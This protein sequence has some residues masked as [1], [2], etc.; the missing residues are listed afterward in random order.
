MCREGLGASPRVGRPLSFFQNPSRH[1]ILISLN[2]N[3]MLK[4]GNT[5]IRP[6]FSVDYIV[7]LDDAEILRTKDYQVALACC[8]AFRRNHPGRDA[9]RIRTN[10]DIRR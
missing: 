3:P 10:M 7:Y 8:I 2:P 1:L 4:Y 6:V 9:K 5:F